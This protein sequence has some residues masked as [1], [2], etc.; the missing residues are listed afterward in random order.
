[1]VRFHPKKTPKA[2][3]LHTFRAQ[4]GQIFPQKNTQGYSLTYFSSPKWSDF[5][6]QKNTQAYIALLTFRAKNGQIPLG[7][8]VM[9]KFGM[10][11]LAHWERLLL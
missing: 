1:M 7:V 8:I 10:D 9:K 6:T 3:A 11:Y 5:P 4:N 2:I